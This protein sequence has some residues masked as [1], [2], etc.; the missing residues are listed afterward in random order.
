MAFHSGSAPLFVPTCPLD[1][2]NSGLKFFEM[3]GW[4]HSSKR[5]HVYQLDM[6]SIAYIALEI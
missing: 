1:K 2:N 3:D 5:G 4:P 6:V